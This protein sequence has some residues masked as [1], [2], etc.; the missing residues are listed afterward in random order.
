MVPT[1]RGK[2]PPLNFARYAA[3]LCEAA[4]SLFAL[5]L[6]HCVDDIIAVEPEQ[7]V[8]SG[9]LA[10]K[11]LCMVTG[12]ATSPTK[13][14]PPSAVFLVIGVEIDLSKT[15]YE[16]PVL[17]V[18]AKRVVQLEKLLANIKSTKRLGPGCAASL[19]RKLGFSLCACYGRFGRAKLR[20]F[21]RRA[22]EDRSGLNRQLLAAIEFWAAF[23]QK[24]V[25]R[26]VPCI[27]KT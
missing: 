19:T 24:Y 15:P 1:V 4:G 23:F 25:P 9:N 22:G 17:K 21:I 7:L 5:P 16:D 26:E 14:P 8:E 11:V 20:P 6:T 18:S 27:S 2:S 3:W 12:W 10:F 13:A